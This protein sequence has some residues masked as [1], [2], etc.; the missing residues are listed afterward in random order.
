MGSSAGAGAGASLASCAPTGAALTLVVDNSDCIPQDSS[1]ILSA[2]S[3]TRAASPTARDP[4]TCARTGNVP[5][6]RVTSLNNPAPSGYDL[7]RAMTTIGMHYDVVAGKEEEFERGFLK[8]IEHLKSVPGHVD[9]H[10]YEDVQSIGSYVIL[11]EWETQD[12]FTAFLRSDAFKQVTAWGRA[13][14]LRGRPRHKVYND[15]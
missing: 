13:E 4:R 12:A 9:S 14:I 11:S 15:A 6:E 3:R 1:A 7:P 2:L 10:L 8:V 5:H